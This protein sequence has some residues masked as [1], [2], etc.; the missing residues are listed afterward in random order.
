MD[1]RGVQPAYLYYPARRSELY[2][3]VSVAS[4]KLL[5]S[6]VLTTVCIV[7]L[8]K[9]ALGTIQLQSMMTYVYIGYLSIWLLSEYVM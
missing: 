9:I 4:G 6:F 1:K 5:L 2:S 3:V 8:S 7:V